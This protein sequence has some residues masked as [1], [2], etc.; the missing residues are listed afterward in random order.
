MK[1]NGSNRYRSENAYRGG[2]RYHV[3]RG[4]KSKATNALKCAG[5][6]N[7]SSPKLT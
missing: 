1:Y 3:N 7:Q 6:V 2:T 5:T 4:K